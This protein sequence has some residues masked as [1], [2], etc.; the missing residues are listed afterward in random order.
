[1]KKLDM[2]NKYKDISYDFHEIIE[3]TPIYCKTLGYF[4]RL[5]EDFCVL[6]SNSLDNKPLT[7]EQENSHHLFVKEL[8]FLKREL[9]KYNENHWLC[10]LMENGVECFYL[11]LMDKARLFKSYIHNII[12]KDDV[13]GIISD[14]LVQYKLEDKSLIK[15]R[16]IWI[17]KFLLFD[18]NEKMNKLMEE[19]ASIPQININIQNTGISTSVFKHDDMIFTKPIGSGIT[20]TIYHG[21]NKNTNEVVAIKR[22]R[23]EKYLSLLEK[24]TDILSSLNHPNILHCS[25]A[26]WKSPYC[27]LTEFAQGGTLF[28]EI[29]KRKKYS[30][31]EKKVIGLNIAKGLLYM[32]SKG[33]IHCD[34]TPFNILLDNDGNPKICDFGS[35]IMS[36]GVDSKQHPIIPNRWS[37]PEC[38]KSNQFSEKS[39]VYSYGMIL[40]EMFTGII[41]YSSIMNDDLNYDVISQ[42]FPE[43]PNTIGDPIRSIISCCLSAI[44]Q[45]KHFESI[46]YMFDE[47][48]G[49][50][51]SENEVQLIKS[52]NVNEEIT[53]PVFNPIIESVKPVEIEIIS[54]EPLACDNSCITQV[55]SLSHIPVLSETNQ[56]HSVLRNMPRQA[57]SIRFLSESIH[58]V[59]T[60]DDELDKRIV[61]ATIE[62]GN[63]DQAILYAK[64]ESMLC[65]A[66]EV[67]AERGVN[68]QLKEAIADKCVTFLS[69]NNPLLVL[70]SLRCLA[71]IKEEKRI[72][73]NVFSKY[74]VEGSDDIKKTLFII[75]A[76]LSK[77]SSQVVNLIFE[78]ALSHVH[79]MPSAEAFL[80]Q[81]CYSPEL[82]LQV[83]NRLV[84]GDP[85]PKM[86]ATKILLISAQHE[87]VHV[88]I[89][90]ALTK[91]DLS[92]SDE[93]ITKAIEKLKLFIAKKSTEK[94]KWLV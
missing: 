14:D 65:F 40:L 61:M 38:F 24:E 76:S 45:R 47:R 10:Y 82:S 25:G 72:P 68:I 89:Q 86:I 70:S 29:H 39:D 11:F 35:S 26:I 7:D 46:V 73:S 31:D 60:G 30:N 36:N 87:I 15:S 94:K 22:Y 32:H 17:K 28:Q 85:I 9:M 56:I 6:F 69:S 88:A 90:F 3:R 93:I 12:N 84:F 48:K 81:S 59:P 34:I 27:L 51:N 44:D 43:I 79:R 62:N 57:V 2:L 33:I 42:S 49:T 37:A 66:L 50:E 53:K 77:T 64:D 41:P 91:L 16:L 80:Y 4:Y 18:D 52:M 1:M 74:L 54:V 5:F 58:H 67:V 63:A 71:G 19:L 92:S 83:V 75:G 55:H 23:K 21:M 13:F 78:S 8:L 20:S